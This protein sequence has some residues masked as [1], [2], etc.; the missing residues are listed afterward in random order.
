MAAPIDFY[1]D[2]I[3]PYAYVGSTQIEALAARHGRTVEWRPVLIG[4][5][6]MKVM[7]IKPLTQ[8]PLKQDYQRHDS[9]HMAA[10]YGVPFKYHGLGS[11][12]ALAALRAF[13]W[14]KARDPQLAVRFAHRIF[15]RLWVDNRRVE[16]VEAVVEEASALGVKSD[17]L[18]AA[19]A[20]PEAKQALFDAVDH[21]VARKVFG[22]P[23]FVADGEPIWGSDRLWM[24][25][26]WLAHGS[27]EGAGAK[28]LSHSG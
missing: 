8:T 3:S 25:D 9:A 11:I 13:L 20:S 7:G 12:N 1:F 23:F 26:H 24:L 19:V 28:V 17:E 2:F 10:I 15:K 6:I 16:P 14:L 22:V 27:W 21:A 18:A 4:I 5:T